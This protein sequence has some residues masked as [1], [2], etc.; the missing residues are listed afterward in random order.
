MY[1]LGVNLRSKFMN[2]CKSFKVFKDN[3]HKCLDLVIIIGSGSR[4]VLNDNDVCI[5]KD[6]IFAVYVMMN[7]C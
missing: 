7:R 3:Y 6:Y 2:Q 4:E 1:V 5:S